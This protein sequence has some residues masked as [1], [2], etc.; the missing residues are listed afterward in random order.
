MLL[1]TVV[2]FA[3]SAAAEPARDMPTINPAPEAAFCPETPMSLAR[4]LGKRPPEA[5][6]LAK[7][8]P[9]KTFMAVD[10]RIAGCPAPL[11]MSDYR[12]VRR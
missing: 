9:A 4:K 12:R 5:V 6:P 2:L 8:P 11:T 10:R 7:L 1:L 3:A